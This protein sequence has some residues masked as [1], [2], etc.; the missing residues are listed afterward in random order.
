METRGMDQLAQFLSDLGDAALKQKGDEVIVDGHAAAEFVTKHGVIA[1]FYWPLLCGYIERLLQRGDGDT[2]RGLVF[3]ANALAVGLQGGKLEGS[4]SQ[5][6]YRL[7]QECGVEN[8]T[9]SHKPATNMRK[10]KCGIC[11]GDCYILCTKSA[12]QI[13][14]FE[15]TLSENERIGGGVCYTCKEFVCFARCAERIPAPEDPSDPLFA[16]RKGR[17]VWA[18]TYKCPLCGS[19]LR[20]AVTEKR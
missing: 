4:Y 6:A 1:P 18:Y 16:S 9:Q 5:V 3:Y 19:V 11:G 10:A 15:A 2:A 14:A 12:G 20:N 8:T 13:L 7:A 17:G